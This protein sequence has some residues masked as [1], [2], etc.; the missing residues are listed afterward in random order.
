MRKSVRIALLNPLALIVFLTAAN[1]ADPGDPSV[2]QRDTEVVLKSGATMNFQRDVPITLR[3]GHVVYANV[4]RPKQQGRYPVILTQTV[5][6]KDPNF[7]DAYKT[8]FEELVKNEVPDLCEKSSC[9]FIKWE[10]TDPE[11]WIP[12]S[13]AV[14]VVDVRGSGKSPGLLDS[15]SPRE[16]SDYYDVIEWAGVQPWSSGKVGLLGTSYLAMNQWQVAA[17]QPPHLAAIVP[18]EG[19]SDWYRE[20]SYHG[21]I[22]SNFFAR[23]WSGTQIAPNAHGNGRTPYRDPDTADA[24]TGTP[25]AEYFLNANVAPRTSRPLEDEA[26]KQVTP[27]FS[28]IKVPL[29]SAGNWGGMGLHG[30]GNIEAYLQAGSAHKWLE[31]HSGT[32]HGKFYSDAGLALQKKFFDHYLK[33]VENGWESAAPVTIAVRNPGGEVVREEKEWPL[34]RTQWTNYYLDA[35]NSGIAQQP[36][37]QDAI[38]TFSATKSA[39]VLSTAPMESDT[40]FT[41]PLAAHLW[42]SSSTTDADL[43]LTLQAFDPAGKEVTFVG[44]SD[45][46]VP[47]AQ[48]WLRASHRALDLTRTLSYRP[49]HSHQ[50]ID[51]LE[52]GKAYSVDV[53]IWPT[54]MVFPRGYR[55]AL[56]I[57]GKDFERSGAAESTV[58]RSS[59]V[60]AGSGP[61]LHTDP[62]DRPVP[63]FAGETSIFTGPARESFLVLP[64]IPANAP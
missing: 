21:G 3:D 17:L 55:L 31:M 29:L 25:L 16:T 22:L 59:T 32:H 1:A 54:S 27:I 52:P 12:E 35:A 7:R 56:R 28:R 5:Y 37:K 51:K 23:Q 45:P 63:E 30:R 62:N 42:I 53:E 46:A 40:E 18:W 8:R 20:V 24:T 58:G 9:N 48:G 49:W 38:A 14:M 13:Y 57:E 6:G 36:P 10:V 19:A 26:Y 61:F 47:V 39:L 4:Y 50:S 34:A 44:A 41:G 33:G 43:F 64:L 2:R 15:L 60:A 11:R